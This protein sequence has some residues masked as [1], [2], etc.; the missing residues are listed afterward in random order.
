MLSIPPRSSALRRIRLYKN[1]YSETEWDSG[2]IRLRIR[3]YA[4]SGAFVISE[5]NTQNNGLIIND[6]IVSKENT[7]TE[8]KSLLASTTN[9]RELGGLEITYG[10]TKCGV[11]WR[12]DAP[13][14]PTAEDIALLKEKGITTFIDLRTDEEREVRP[15]AL[16]DTAG[17]E[18]HSFPVTEGAELPASLEEVPLSYMQIASSKAMKDVFSTIASAKGGVMF[19]C[20]AGKDRT[21]VVSAVIQL[22]CGVKDKEIIA[23]YAV[24][25]EYNKKRLEA[26]LAAYPEIDR[27]A[28][29]A[30]EMSMERFIGMFL[31]EYGSVQGYFDKTGLPRETLD[32]IRHKLT[33]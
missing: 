32:A 3:I 29:L 25:R 33:D 16:A 30:N 10:R 5:D 13:L 22:A 2:Y 6:I 31:E 20:A 21:G 7:M 27:R 17:F 8:Y 26:F 1:M 24:S 18:Y 19:F 9:T 23:D 12:S 11:I 28:V 15:T 4:C 14:Q